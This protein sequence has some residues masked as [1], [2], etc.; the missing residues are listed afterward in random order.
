MTGIEP[1]ANEL[2]YTRIFAAPRDLVFRCMTEPRHLTRFWGPKG[3]TTPVD[4]I[5]IDLRSGGVFQT[6]MV[7]DDDGTQ[8]TMTATYLTVHPPELLVWVDSDTGATTSTTFTSLDDA[9]TE[10]EIRQSNVPPAFQTPEN[11]AG[12]A[13]SLDRFADYLTSLTDKGSPP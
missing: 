8:Y 11:R 4:G 1:S 5:E 6:V 3:M 7:Y 12:F 9:R 13:T 2:V 10:V